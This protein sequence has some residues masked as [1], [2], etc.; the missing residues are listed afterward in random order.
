MGIQLRVFRRFLRR[1]PAYYREYCQIKRSAPPEWPCRLS[2]PCLDDKGEGAGSAQ[3]HYFHQDFLVAQRIFAKNPQRHVDI[4][5]RIDGFVAHVAVFRPI[6]IIDI[7]PLPVLHNVTTLQLDVANGDGLPQHITDS[8]SCLHVIEHFGLGRY[9]DPLGI[10]AW[11]QGFRNMVTML[12]PG[13]RFYFSTPVGVQRIEFN[14]HRVF[15]PQ[16]ILT[17]ATKLNLQLQYFSYVDDA[18]ALHPGVQLTPELLQSLGQATY[19]C[20]IFEF[21]K[22]GF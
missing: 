8:L 17:L 16:T 14:A 19:S 7:R 13:G 2:Y 1:V 20:G 9:G 18:G 3:G 11:Q 22:Q 10:T 6:E 15:H 21:V 12:A 5:S 4:G